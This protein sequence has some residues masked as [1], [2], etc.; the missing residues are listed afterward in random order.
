MGTTRGSHFL[1]R[2]DTDI[3]FVVCWFFNVET[4]GV[5]RG[6]RFLI[7]EVFPLMTMTVPAATV[8]PQPSYLTDAE[9][10]ERMDKL[11]AY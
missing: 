3:R 7:L 4:G 9:T 2:S 1:S 8:W 11:A 5:S 10:G 6:T